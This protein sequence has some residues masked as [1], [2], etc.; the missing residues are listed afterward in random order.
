MKFA[1]PNIIIEPT[2]DHVKKSLT[3]IAESI[4]KTTDKVTWWGGERVGESFLFDIEQEV[5]VNST[6]KQLKRVVT[7]EDAM[8]LS[9]TLV[10]SDHAMHRGVGEG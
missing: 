2:L 3:V 5:A 9:S 1:I 4:L 10:G 6:L 8:L 7:G